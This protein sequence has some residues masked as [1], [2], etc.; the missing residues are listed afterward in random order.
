[1]LDVAPLYEQYAPLIRAWF[2][3]RLPKGDDGLAEEL[4]STVFEKVVRAAPRYPEQI[5]QPS[6]WLFRIATTTLIDWAE[7]KRPDVGLPDMDAHRVTTDAGSDAHLTQLALRGRLPR[8]NPAYR[9]ILEARFIRGETVHE[10][11]NRESVP[12]ATIRGR[13]ARATEALRDLWAAV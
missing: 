8:L 7:K 13:Q 2:W 5:E 3:A 6:S 12:A 9:A 10:I 11:A 4:T 1:M